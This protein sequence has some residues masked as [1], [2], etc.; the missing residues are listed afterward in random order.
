MADNA[1]ISTASGNVV[2]AADEPDEGA[3]LAN[4]PVCLDDELAG[5]DELR[6]AR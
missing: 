3:P 1:T 5:P 6:A 4:E 2:V